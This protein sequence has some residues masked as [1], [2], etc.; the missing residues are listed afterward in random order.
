MTGDEIGES[1]S[2]PNERPLEIFSAQSR[3]VQQSA[4]RNPLQTFLDRIRTHIDA[5]LKI[6][7]QLQESDRNRNSLFSIADCSAR[8]HFR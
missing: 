5:S 4:V 3:A 8:R 7:G 1:G 6:S 2:H